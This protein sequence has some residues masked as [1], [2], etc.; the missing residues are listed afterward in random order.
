MG[1]TC[2]G[3]SHGQAYRIVVL[4]NQ[5]WIAPITLPNGPANESPAPVPME[6]MCRAAP[7]ESGGSRPFPSAPNSATITIINSEST[8]GCSLVLLG[9]YGWCWLP[10]HFRPLANRFAL[11]AADLN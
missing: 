5:H 10:Q 6:A 3:N 2:S 7:P 11:E 1:M 9:F 4:A 8:R